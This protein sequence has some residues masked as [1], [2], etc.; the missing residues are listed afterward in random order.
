MYNNKRSSRPA[1]IKILRHSP[2]NYPE[3]KLEISYDY[4]QT[5]TRAST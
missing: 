5:H 2:T 3:G 1:V 4:H